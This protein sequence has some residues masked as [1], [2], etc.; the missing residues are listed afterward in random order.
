[1]FGITGM[2]ATCFCHPLDVIRVN[3]QTGSFKGPI[4]CGMKL[5]A[6]QGVFR[7]LYAGL[8]AAFLRQWTYSVGDDIGLFSV[9]F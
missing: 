5:Y 4:D 6:S 9:I 7:G 8:S 3:M 2:G 1:M